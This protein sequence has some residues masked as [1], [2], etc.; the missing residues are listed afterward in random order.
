MKEEEKDRMV[1]SWEEKQLRSNGP[2]VDACHTSSSNR[3]IALGRGS[4]LQ[5]SSGT[6]LS[7]VCPMLP[8]VLLLPSVFLRSL[9]FNDS[10]HPFHAFIPTSPTR[11]PLSSSGSSVKPSHTRLPSPV[12]PTFPRPTTIAPNATLSQTL[13]EHV[14]ITYNLYMY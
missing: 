2:A 6:T 1:E 7:T 13:F 14:L 8:R 11:C 12:V 9:I 10:I 4:I 5:L 3:D